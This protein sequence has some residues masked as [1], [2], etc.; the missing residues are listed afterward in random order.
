MDDEF[1]IFT[2]IRVPPDITQMTINLKA[3]IVI[4]VTTQKGCQVIVE[5]EQYKVRVPVYDTLK[6]LKEEK[7][8]EI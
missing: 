7:K 5:D 3:P 2:T 8:T 1:A 6:S 4:N